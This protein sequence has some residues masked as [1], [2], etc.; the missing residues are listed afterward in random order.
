MARRSIIVAARRDLGA[1]R[2]A[3]LR[4]RGGDG[5]G[6]RAR[7]HERAVR[8][9]GELPLDAGAPALNTS[10]SVFRSDGPCA[11]PVS[12]RRQIQGSPYPGNTTT[13]YIDTVGR[14]RLSATTSRPPISSAT[15][16]S[17]GLT[18]IVD[19]HDPAATI[20]IPNASSAGVVS[21][22]VTLAATSADAASGVASSVL[23][24]GAVGACPV[25][26]GDGLHLGHGDVSRNGP[27][28]VC[29]VVTDNAGHVAIATIT[30]TRRERRRPPP[31]RRPGRPLGRQDGA[32]HADEAQRHPAAR[33]AGREDG[34][35]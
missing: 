25:G 7:A 4:G 20:A 32:R 15:A 5:A 3:A 30:V 21:G 31:L 18:V 29:N 12:R 2:A 8:D 14:R 22:I 1:R 17:P 10:Q 23:H 6:R 19:T 24:V 34:C 11:T 27:Y 28:D 16:N 9:P 13:D 33:E 35:A 26:A